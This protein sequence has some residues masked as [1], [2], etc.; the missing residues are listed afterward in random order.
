MTPEVEQAYNNMSQFRLQEYTDYWQSIKAKNDA[1]Y[2]QRFLF[3]FCS[4]HTTWKSN[5]NGYEAIKDF[6]PAHWSQT[7][8]LGALVSSGCGMHFNRAKYIWSFGL[9]YWDDPSDYQ[10]TASEPWWALRDRLVCSIKGLGLAKVSFALEMGDPLEAAV[11]CLD[12]H[13]IRLYGLEK[14]NTGHTTGKDA[15]KYSQFE[16]DWISRARQ[17]KVAPYVARMVYWDSVQ[18]QSSSRYWSH[19]LED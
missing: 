14:L 8:L 2:F 19:V 3:A 11:T 10:K 9:K 15:C 17:I 1:E 16:M 5:V 12:V 6:H 4:V 18:K 13:M 7:R